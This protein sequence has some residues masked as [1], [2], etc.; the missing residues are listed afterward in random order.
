MSKDMEKLTWI[1]GES[2]LTPWSA[3]QHRLNI[4]DGDNNHGAPSIETKGPYVLDSKGLG[5]ILSMWCVKQE[6]EKFIPPCRRSRAKWLG[7]L[8]PEALQTSKPYGWTS[9][10]RPQSQSRDEILSIN[11]LTISTSQEYSWDLET[12]GRVIRNQRKGR[13]SIFTANTSEYL[14]NPYPRPM[15]WPLNREVH[16]QDARDLPDTDSSS[17][18]EQESGCLPQSRLCGETWLCSW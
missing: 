4:R 10:I 6:K 7:N 11:N 18:I 2:A 15:D 13:G 16:A 12:M 5:S 8:R 9:E 17:R 14:L 3:Y 1:N